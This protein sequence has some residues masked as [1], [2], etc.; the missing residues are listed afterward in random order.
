MTVEKKCHKLILSLLLCYFVFV[1][2]LVTLSKPPGLTAYGNN[3]GM[4]QPNNRL[5]LDPTGVLNLDLKSVTRD[6]S[7]GSIFRRPQAAKVSK[8]DKII[9]TFST[10]AP[11]NRE[12]RDFPGGY[13]VHAVGF[14]AGDII[15]AGI[16]L[17][18]R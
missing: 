15:T 17:R 9:S 1:T 14:D 10:G 13:Y 16:V 6:A 7:K 5:V 2:H 12:L 11:I 3:G 18:G 8:P 4:R